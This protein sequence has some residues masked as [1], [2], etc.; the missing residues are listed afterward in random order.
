MVT[1]LVSG[2]ALMATGIALPDLGALLVLGLIAALGG[3]GYTFTLTCPRCGTPIFKRKTTI[4]GI[5]VTYWGG[6]TVPRT[7]SRCGLQ[8]P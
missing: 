3:A 2:F 4:D 1:A 7:C 8:L 5:D 6:F